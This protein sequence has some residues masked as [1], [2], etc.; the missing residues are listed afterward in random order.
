M[1]LEKAR[2]LLG[3]SAE[4]HKWEGI[5]RERE[6]PSEAAF[7]GHRGSCL[8]SVPGRVMF[9]APSLV[10]PLSWLPPLGI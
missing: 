1:K 5:H 8:H 2:V 7:P 10:L 9:Q 4:S 3:H 6:T